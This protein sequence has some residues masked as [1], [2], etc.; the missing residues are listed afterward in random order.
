MPAAAV[1]A[2][3]TVASSV[4]S[5]NAAGDAA[6]KQA[7]ALR[8]SAAISYAA[9]QKARQEILNRMEPALQNYGDAIA[10]AQD[11]IKSGTADVMQLLQQ[12][13][14]QA[15]RIF[16]TM[17]IDA[18]KALLGSAATAQGIPRQSFE[19]Q[20]ITAT[21][22]QTPAG[23]PQPGATPPAGTVP[24]GGIAAAQPATQQLPALATTAQQ[25]TTT[26]TAAPAIAQSQ[27]QLPAG[28][29]YAGAQQALQTGEQQAMSALLQSTG[30]ARADIQ[31]GQ[32]QSLQSITE[33]RN[34]ALS[35]YSPYT[36]AGQAAIEKEAALSGVLGPE[37]QQAA[38][39]AYIESP[40]QKYLREQQ[41]KALL[42]SGAA[43]GGL[44]SGRIRSALMEQAMNIA[45][46]QQQ[47]QLE[48]YRSLAQRGQAAVGDVGS[49]Y[50]GAGTQ[51]ANIQAGAAQNLANLASSLGIN[52]SQLMSASSAEKSALAERTGINLAQLEQ[53]IGSARAAGVSSL[54][55]ALA[56]AA[57]AQA[58]DIAQLQSQAATT[59][60]SGQQNIAQI[61]S[62]LAVGAGTQAAEYTGLAGTALGTGSYLQGQQYAQGISD[63]S[64]L[65]AY[66]LSK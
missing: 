51:A 9:A 55:T 35:G 17:G 41:E 59:Q 28:I 37:A 19:Q 12:S 36:E 44:G 66:Q 40:G 53:T 20:Y 60:L 38:I 39:D 27:E 3:G 30:T 1:A 64:K 54:G 49:I 56:G 18:K 32:Q 50:T 57:G 21:G 29:G 11:S 58:G 8:D 52:A 7:G 43:T 22:G 61:L 47:Q 23:L 25:T 45:S 15:D 10:G 2:V 24:A 5:A 63:L 48:N 16:Q 34:Q 14:G 65:A 46:T 62:N 6:S 26:P 31:T 13:T 33:A 4:I 42:R